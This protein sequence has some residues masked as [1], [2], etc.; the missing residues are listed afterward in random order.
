[1]R[2]CRTQLR[3]ARR[4]WPSMPARCFLRSGFQSELSNRLSWCLSLKLRRKSPNFCSGSSSSAFNNALWKRWCTCPFRVHRNRS[5][6]WSRGFFLDRVSELIME[7]IADIPMQE[8]MGR[9]L[10]RG[11]SRRLKNELR[12]ASWQGSLTSVF[13][14]Q[15]GEIIEVVK[16][17][18]TGPGAASRCGANRATDPGR[19]RGGREVHP[20]RA[21]ATARV[22]AC[23]SSVHRQ[24]TGHTANGRSDEEERERRSKGKVAR[25]GEEERMDPLPR[26]VPLEDACREPKVA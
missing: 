17:H 24:S 21:R 3:G 1:M 10:R 2:S 11:F 22:C 23:T 7:Q 25:K 20:S 26:A 4:A 14:Q 15:M 8:S 12:S 6:R 19:N 9:K 13:P 16:L 18:S 5:A